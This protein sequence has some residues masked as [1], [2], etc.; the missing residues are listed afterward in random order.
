MKKSLIAL[1][2]IAAGAYAS[3]QLEIK[4]GDKFDAP[5]DV[6]DKML[7]D[8][9]VELAPDADGKPQKAVKRTKVRLL[10]DSALGNAN[11][12]VEI[13]ADQVKQCESDG[14]ADSSKAA[15]TY[16]LGLEQNKPPA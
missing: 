5:D 2:A 16:A 14:I 3:N 10:I 4:A 13:D 8:K 9:V 12:V 7:A 11:D 1:A 15:V 6:A